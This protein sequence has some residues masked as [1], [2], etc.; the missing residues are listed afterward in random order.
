MRRGFTLIELLVVIA[1]IAILA[2]ILFPV[3]AR[4]RE[5]AR[6]ASCQSN[7]KQI[8]LGEMMYDQDFDE[9]CHYCVG[10]GTGYNFMGGGGCGGCFQR[11]EAN[12]GNL[13]AGPGRNYAPL[14]PYI[15][16]TQ[17]WHCPSAPDEFRSYNWNRGCDR[18][19]IAVITAPAQTPMFADASQSLTGGNANI[20]WMTHN[21]GDVNTD[22]NCC[23]SG[24]AAAGQPNFRPHHISDIHHGGANIAFWDG[25]VKYMNMS[26]IPAGRRGSGIK[27]A[28]EDP[29]S[30]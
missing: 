17:L 7:L 27:F 2:A 3:F 1:I 29:V 12:W 22:A 24:P 25:H 13:C 18:R 4:A 15:K 8:A 6:Q 19:K 10:E 28:A 30:P 20:A 9:M 14:T 26:G 21:W 5:K 23:N 16:N 11:Y